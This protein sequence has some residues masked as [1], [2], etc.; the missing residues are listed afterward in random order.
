M[1]LLLSFF[2]LSQGLLIPLFPLFERNGSNFATAI[3]SVIHNMKKRI[4][5]TYM[6]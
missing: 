1:R 2:P 3:R 6:A 5:T 4:H